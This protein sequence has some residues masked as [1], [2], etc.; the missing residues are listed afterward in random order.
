MRRLITFN[1]IL[2]LVGMLMCIGIPVGVPQA[3]AN[4]L[5]F[6]DDQLGITNNV[7]TTGDLPLPGSGT[8]TITGA[9]SPTVDLSKAGPFFWGEDNAEK[10]FKIKV[11]KPSVVS[12]SA[13]L[14]AVATADLEAW[15]VLPPQD[16]MD[17]AVEQDALDS[18]SGVVGLGV[19]SIP[20]NILLPGVT[21]FYALSDFECRTCNSGQPFYSDPAKYV[22]TITVGEAATDVHV[23]SGPFSF[24]TAARF[25]SGNGRLEVNRFSI[26]ET[27]GLKGKVQIVGIKYVMFTPETFNFNRNSPVGDTFNFVAFAA[28]PGTQQPPDNPRLIAN[29]KIE[30]TSL[31]SATKTFTEVI[32]DP[33]LLVNAED[34]LFAGM[35]LD[36]RNPGANS[37]NLGRNLILAWFWDTDRSH[38]RTWA[39]MSTSNQ[40]TL[41]GWQPEAFTLNGMTGMGP[42]M[43]RIV[44]KVPQAGQIMIVEPGEAT[45][46][47]L[48]PVN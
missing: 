9:I 34:E 38:G 42:L 18:T 11:D 25:T 29:R 43:F 3:S 12:F 5:A 8:L 26:A 47:N 13:N 44:V 14:T 23:E 24:G 15:L 27:T 28:P 6:T 22:V 33:P 2:G 32:L 21:Y 37:V 39:T 40:P 31:A 20:P 46:A 16:S 30:I 36:Y 35:F 19:K 17:H 45:K 48:D 10:I 1:A 7:V 41:S 4:D